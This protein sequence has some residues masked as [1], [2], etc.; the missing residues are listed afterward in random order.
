MEWT[1]G[2]FDKVDLELEGIGG[3][4]ASEVRRQQD[5]HRTIKISRD[6][7]NQAPHGFPCNVFNRYI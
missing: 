4:K 3:S 1:G 2:E 6:N 5:T 7:N